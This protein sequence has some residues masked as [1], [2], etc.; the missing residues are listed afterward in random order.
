MAENKAPLSLN[1]FH[2]PKLKKDLTLK[3][4]KA[5]LQS[6]KN[7]TQQSGD[8]TITQDAAAAS[9]I[10]SPD[11]VCA[12][13]STCK[14][15]ATRKSKRSKAR[16]VST[17]P[18]ASQTVY[19]DAIQSPDDAS[20]RTQQKRGS[21][22]SREAVLASA[23]A[24]E[25]AAA[26]EDMFAT[27]PEP[28]EADYDTDC[29][30]VATV[31]QAPD[32]GTA[33]RACSAQPSQQQEQCEARVQ[34]AA[35]VETG[36]RTAGADA[37]VNKRKN[38]PRGRHTGAADTAAAGSRSQRQHGAVAAAKAAAEASIVG[39]D[40]EERVHS[41]EGEDQQQQHG[42]APAGKQ[43]LK[44]GQE[45]FKYLQRLAEDA[46]ELLPQEQEQK[47]RGR[48]RPKKDLSLVDALHQ[49]WN[50][51]VSFDISEA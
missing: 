51:K 12:P 47:K 3:T 26:D 20:T 42:S 23:A 13:S 9:D 28:M 45:I 6:K 29:A 41:K 24:P 49:C 30:D 50:G 46:A 34:V 8:N 16:V 22:R 14:A 32:D 21:T 10:A 40:G 17:G 36:N 2:L 15:T 31:R 43:S 33:S 35:A 19:Y 39:D 27:Q 37:G 25:A 18:E 11:V 44:D 5:D 48:G 38:V 1:V 7:A 4:Q